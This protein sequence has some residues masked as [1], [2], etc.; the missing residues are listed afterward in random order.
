M[1]ERGSTVESLIKNLNRLA[2]KIKCADATRNLGL[3]ASYDTMAA[4]SY[5]WAGEAAAPR[6][7]YRASLATLWADA[8]S[9]TYNFLRTLTAE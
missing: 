3:I 8:T 1:D 7:A 4:K 6:I 2:S 9:V 5:N